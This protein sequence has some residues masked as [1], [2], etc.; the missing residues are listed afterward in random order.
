MM[1]AKLERA[2]EMARSLPAREQQDL[3]LAMLALMGADEDEEP[4]PLTSD[5]KLAIARSRE[6]AAR[7]EFASEADIEALWKKH[8]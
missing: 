5:E 7:G 3:A 6:S 1:N 4:I 8:T 2:V